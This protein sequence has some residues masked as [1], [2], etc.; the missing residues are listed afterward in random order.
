MYFK[1]MHNIKRLLCML[2]LIN[3]GFVFAFRYHPPEIQ[4]VVRA[5]TL[6]ILVVVS[7]IWFSGNLV[8]TYGELYDSFI[9][10]NTDT[11]IKKTIIMVIFDVVVHV[12]P[13]ILIGLPIHSSSIIIAYGCLLVWYS[14]FG[15]KIG[16]I[17]VPSI[18][19]KKAV[20]VAGIFTVCF[21][22]WKEL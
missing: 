22:L 16:E 13:V 5:T 21:A 8:C 14:V 6:L 9:K 1:G 12:L 15:D 19:G 11:P 18:D 2:T 3:L 20:I 4:D 10:N 17:Y 7:S